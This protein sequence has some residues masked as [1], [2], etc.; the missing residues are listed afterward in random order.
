M[1]LAEELQ[2]LE[3]K[4]SSGH[5][6]VTRPDMCAVALRIAAAVQQ[7]WPIYVGVPA[8]IGRK[9]IEVLYKAA[10]LATEQGIGPEAFATQ[11]LAGMARKSK[12]W[13]SSL[14][15][16]VYAEGQPEAEELK[17]LQLRGYK[18][19]LALFTS[20][21][22]LYGPQLAIRDRANSFSALFRYVLATEYALPEIAESLRKDA[23]LEWASSTA[24]QDLFDKP[25]DR[26][27]LQ[28]RAPEHPASADATEPCHS[29]AGA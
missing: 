2:L 6:S 13:L 25:D 9:H 20:R 23:A 21:C 22:K 19:Q 17:L 12:F 5:M 26:T 14:A 7:I 1:N 27:I 28:Q 24:A 16:P 15:S 8:R 29:G 4:N 18:S 11:Q 3:W 10:L